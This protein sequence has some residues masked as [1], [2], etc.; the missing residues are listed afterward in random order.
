[1]SDYHS[2]CNILGSN[3]TPYITNLKAKIED[4]KKAIEI[5]KTIELNRYEKR[6]VD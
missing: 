4:L 5:L 3:S 1:M 2:Y 6:N